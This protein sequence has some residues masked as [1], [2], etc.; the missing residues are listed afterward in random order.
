MEELVPAQS[1]STQSK[2]INI[3]ILNR[4]ITFVAQIDALRGKEQKK[5]IVKI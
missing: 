3:Q 1:I 4:K 2:R 5:L